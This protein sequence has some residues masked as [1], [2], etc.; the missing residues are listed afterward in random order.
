MTEP[1][2]T[3]DNC[4]KYVTE[5]GAL[6]EEQATSLILDHICEEMVE[7]MMDDFAFMDLF[8]IYRNGIQAMG[9]SDIQD[10]INL[11]QED[12]DSDTETDDLEPPNDY[13]R[14]RLDQWMEAKVD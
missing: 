9:Q 10:W 2:L 8:D 5:K 4:I 13:I 7:Q 12:Y 11:I 6:N 14:T 1:T 3:V